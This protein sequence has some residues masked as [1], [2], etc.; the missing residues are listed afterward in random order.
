MVN[1]SE[2]ARLLNFYRHRPDRWTEHHL[3]IQLA[4]YR[5]K[6]QLEEF[7][8]LFPQHTWAKQR[9]NMGKLVLGENRSYQAEALARMA[10]PGFYAFKWAN[11]TAKTATAAIIVHWF[12]SCY[13]GARVVTTAGT[14]SQLREQL[15]RELEIWARRAKKLIAASS[16]RM[17]KTHVNLDADWAAFGRAATEESTF[18]GVHGDYVMLLFDEAKAINPGIYNAARRIL[19]GNPDGKFWWICLSSPGSPTGPFFDICHGDASRRWHVFSLSA[20]ESS[21]IQLEQIHEDLLDLGETSP[22]FVSM[23]LGEFPDEGE[24]AVIPL[25]WVQAAAARVNAAPVGRSGG[26]LDIARYG[27]A[28]SVFTKK[29]GVVLTLEDVYTNRSLAVTVGKARIFANKVH[30]L[31]IDDVGM[32]GGV[33]DILRD[34]HV[35]GIIPLNAGARARHPDQFVNAGTEWAWNFREL[36]R[37]S[38]ELKEEDDSKGIAL[39]NDKI[40]MHQLAAR[41]YR[42]RPDGKLQIES[43]EDMKKRGEKSPDRADSA[44]MA[45]WVQ[46]MNPANDRELLKHVAEEAV[47]NKVGNTILEMDF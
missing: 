28:E 25:S 43:K 1:I 44:F 15:W 21:R 7:L 40:L 18:E 10:E 46:A 16:K 12:L 35:K 13:P 34:Q 24:D 26:G 9:L 3:D 27:N 8:T 6:D 36:C 37:A 38:F 22:L 39:P 42:I 2:E 23:D 33:T 11:G 17:G 41:K 14:W 32:G 19:R 29:E 47:G 20:Y 31:G 5:S 4:R 30:A 45:N